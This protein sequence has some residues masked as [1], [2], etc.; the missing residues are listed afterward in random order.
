MRTLALTLMLTLPPLGLAAD[1]V[2]V[3]EAAEPMIQALDAAVETSTL[4]ADYLPGYGLHLSTV[5]QSDELTDAVQARYITTVS[6]ILTG[7]APTIT[8]LEPADYVSY[9]LTLDDYDQEMPA[10]HIVIRAKPG[11][12]TEVWI[13]G[14]QQAQGGSTGI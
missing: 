1:P 7:L 14:E 3:V 8:A 2:A 10:D 6:G 5:Y 9:A 11:R 13:N 4:Y 12:A